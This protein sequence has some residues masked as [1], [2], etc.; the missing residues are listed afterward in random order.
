[1]SEARPTCTQREVKM[2]FHQPQ[3]H[4]S[5]FEHGGLHP[6]EQL[7]I[8]TGALCLSSAQFARKDSFAVLFANEFRLRKCIKYCAAWVEGEGVR[9]APSLGGLP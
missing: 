3:R 7:A 4:R 1:M 2:L 8:L 5:R 9:R 6:L